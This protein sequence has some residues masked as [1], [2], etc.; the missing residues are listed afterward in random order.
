MTTNTIAIAVLLA[1]LAAPPRA[2]A[3][4]S[5]YVPG[6]VLVRFKA[7]ATVQRRVAAF[8][9]QAHSAVAHL[10][11]GWTHVRVR[12]GQN[13]DEALAAYAA[14]PA[15]EYAQ[16]NFIYRA[17]LAPNDPDY[18]QLWGFKNTGQT[19]TSA[20]Q[21][22]GGLYGGNNPG[23]AGD[24][25]NIEPAWDVTTDCSGTVVAVIDSGVNYNHVDL[26]ANMWNG[27]AA[28]PNHGYDY[29]DGDND[30][31]DTNG[32]GTHVAGIIGAEGNDGTGT[33]GVCWTARIMAVRVLNTEG[34]G[35]SAGILQGINFAVD[36]GAKVINM[37]LGGGGTPDPAYSAAIT[38]AQ[39]A[40]V[41]VVVA[42]GNEGRDNETTAVYPCNFTQPNLICVAALDQSFALAS[43]SNWGATSVDV[44]APGTNMLSTWAGTHTVTPEPIV[45]GWSGNM[46]GV[47]SDGVNNYLINPSNYGELGATYDAS[48]DDR[49][50][51]TF[52]FSGASAVT[53]DFSVAID[54][55]A[56]DW[57]RSA[58][59]ASGGDP[60]SGG[61]NLDSASDVHTIGQL[62]P[63]SLDVSAC[64]SATTT[65]GFQLQ[66][67]ATMP[68][69]YGV[70]I[71]PL[72]ITRLVLN[73]ASYNTIDGTS[74][75]TPVVAGIATMLRAYNPQYTAAD[76]VSAIVQ[77]GRAVPSLATTTTSGKAVDAMQSLAYIH[78]PTGVAYVP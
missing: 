28:Y 69:S 2:L 24:D 27:G 32:H 70:A 66:S 54:V 52:D 11:D 17:A 68:K 1:A 40:G 36:R 39:T 26:A 23:T 77:G 35:T 74:M 14:D 3:A 13:V 64:A 20:V 46:W 41:V 9:A 57:V 16:P 51:K 58:C 59:K 49:V 12:P 60:F 25:V 31:M 73:A 30:P 65:V 48:T 76:V 42:A 33:T 38:N 53:I 15:V 4:P 50:W 18:G 21:P 72:T 19:V 71:S 62:V 44:G 37:S 10:H 45:S 63:A 78:P 6:E 8:A 61:T 67:N 55:N 56:G 75:A 22:P 29:V 43:F 47:G 34:A 5:P 7:D